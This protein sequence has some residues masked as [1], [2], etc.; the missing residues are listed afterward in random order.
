MKEMSVD[1]TTVASIMSVTSQHSTPC[2]STFHRFRGCLQPAQ[3]FL[4][5]CY[6][7]LSG[8][9]RLLPWDLIQL[10][11]PINHESALHIFHWQILGFLFMIAS[12]AFVYS[13]CGLITL[14]ILY[15]LMPSYTVYV[16]T[17]TFAYFC[18]HNLPHF[19]NSS[20]FLF[21]FSLTNCEG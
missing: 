4:A 11:L 14:C 21:F 1:P 2:T 12:L 9:V 17:H 3:G 5:S 13:V 8:R 16:V 10:E 20:F 6:F 15:F 19:F 7:I 18:P